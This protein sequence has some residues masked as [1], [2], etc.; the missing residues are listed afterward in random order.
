MYM[1]FHPF[2]STLPQGWDG[3]N[4][5]DYKVASSYQIPTALFNSLKL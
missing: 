4:S 5:L 3:D 1:Y 2:W